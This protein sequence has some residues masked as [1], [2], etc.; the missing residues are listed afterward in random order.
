MCVCVCVYV[1]ACVC[2]CLCA[3]QQLPYQKETFDLSM[4]ILHIV[5]GWKSITSEQ[6]MIITLETEIVLP[7]LV[8]TQWSVGNS[9]R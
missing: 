7:F 2:E 4:D 5:A 8:N 9:M 3:L 6:E 1:L